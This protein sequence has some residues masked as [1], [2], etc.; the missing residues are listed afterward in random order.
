MAIYSIANVKVYMQPKGELLKTRAKKY[1]LDENGKKEDCS[2]IIDTED[3]SFKEYLEGNSGM[4][5]Q[6][7][8]Y[9]WIGTQFYRQLLDFG[10]FYLHSSVV[11]L[12]GKAYIFSADSGTGKSTHTRLWLEYFGKDKAVII[13]D[14]KPAIKS[15]NG[16]LYAYGTPFSGKNDISQNIGVPIKALCFLEQALF[17][18]IEKLSFHEAMYKF[19]HQL[20]CSEKKEYMDKLLSY[21]D[22]FFQNIPIYNLKCTKNESAVITSYNAMK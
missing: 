17:D 19:I 18:E 10:G 15:E 9:A 8:E 12:D 13:N 16:I 4:D 7:V 21:T 6:L 11:A 5:Y 14:D 2:I 22:V 3:E 1:L 20:L